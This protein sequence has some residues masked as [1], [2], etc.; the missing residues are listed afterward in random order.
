M[1][2]VAWDPHAAAR[3]TPAHASLA[4]P[5]G[6]L[7]GSGSERSPGKTRGRVCHALLDGANPKSWHPSGWN[8]GTDSCWTSTGTGSCDLGP[9]H[10]LGLV[11]PVRRVSGSAFALRCRYSTNS[12]GDAESHR[13][14]F[15]LV[16][17]PSVP[18]CEWGHHRRVP[19]L[20][21][22]T[23]SPTSTPLWGR[24]GW[25]QLT[26][27]SSLTSVLTP[28]FGHPTAPLNRRQLHPGPTVPAV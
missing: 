21:H 10:F 24:V 19:E 15:S 5:P 12:H 4:Q 13:V 22:L 26:W 8:L 28:T 18:I 17:S 3:A 25:Q 23:W 2:V 11:G 20:F 16:P 1:L 6:P 7:Q 27:D 9:A 14:T